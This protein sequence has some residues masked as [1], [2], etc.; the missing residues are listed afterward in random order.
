MIQPARNSTSAQQVPTARR[1]QITELVHATCE[2]LDREAFE[3]YLALFHSDAWYEILVYSPDIQKDMVWLAHDKRALT[4]LL[5]MAPR[6][7]RQLGTYFRQSNVEQIQTDDRHHLFSVT[8]SVM[9]VYT[10]IDGA[11]RLFAVARYHDQVSIASGQAPLLVKRSVRLE[12]RDLGAGT[13][14]LI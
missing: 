1:A 5:S 6:H 13:H 8:S 9:V 4:E 2:T 12:T 7:A 14:L 11:S 3:D 10:E